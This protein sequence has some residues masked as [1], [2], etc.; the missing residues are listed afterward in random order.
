MLRFLFL[1]ALLLPSASA[2]TD[3]ATPGNDRL[4]DR[5]DPTTRQAMLDLYHLPI[6]AYWANDEDSLPR[7]NFRNESRTFVIGNML[8][9]PGAGLIGFNGVQL[10]EP[11][12]TGF[13][14][15][16]LQKTDI[17]AMDQCHDFATPD[18]PPDQYAYTAFYPPSDMH[19]FSCKLRDTGAS[20]PT[21]RTSKACTCSTNCFRGPFCTELVDWFTT[22]QLGQPDVTTVCAH[23]SPEEQPCGHFFG[24]RCPSGRTCVRQTEGITIEGFKHPPADVCCATG[25]TGNFCDTLIGCSLGGCGLSATGTTLGGGGTCIKSVNGSYVPPQLSRCINCNAGWKGAWCNETAPIFVSNG[26]NPLPTGRR[27]LALN[28]S[29]PVGTCN[30]QRYDQTSTGIAA[31]LVPSEGGRACDCGVQWRQGSMPGRQLLAVGNIPQGPASALLSRI[32]TPFTYKGAEFADKWAYVRNVGHLDEAKWLCYGDALCSGFYLTLNNNTAF[33]SSAPSRLGVDVPRGEDIWAVGSQFA[34]PETQTWIVNR[35][36]APKYYTNAYAPCTNMTLDWS[37]YAS[38][39]GPQVQS[40]ITN[41]GYGTWYIDPVWPDAFDLAAQVHWRVYGHRVRYSPNSGCKLTTDWREDRKTCL[42]PLS[43]VP[44]IT[45][46]ES[47]YT[48]V[49]GQLSMRSY[50]NCTTA[51]G[52]WALVSGGVLLGA[53][54][55]SGSVSAN[56]TFVDA[57]VV[58][59]YV[60]NASLVVGTGQFMGGPCYGRISGTNFT[61]ASTDTTVCKS[62]STCIYDGVQIEVKGVLTSDMCGNLTSIAARVTAGSLPLNTANELDVPAWSFRALVGEAKGQICSCFP[63]FTYANEHNSTMDCGR[64]QC[65]S[66]GGVGVVNTSYVGR[67]T[68]RFPL[69]YACICSFPYYTDPSTCVNGRCNWCAASRCINLG[70]V[71]RS[72][73]NSYA[74]DCPKTVTGVDCSQLACVANHTNTQDLIATISA[75]QSDKM[76]VGVLYKTFAFVTCQPYCLKGWTGELCE[77]PDCGLLGI[78][79]YDGVSN[80]SCPVGSI[81]N[82]DA[83]GSCDKLACGVEAARGIWVGDA[84]TGSCNCTFPWSGLECKDHVCSSST[85]NGNYSTGVP[86]RRVVTGQLS[87]WECSCTW[88]W[89][90]Q[91]PS[92][93]CTENYCGNWGAPSTSYAPGISD[94]TAACKCTAYGRM[95]IYT[96]PDTCTNSNVNACPKSCNWGSCGI[97]PTLASAYP[98]AEVGDAIGQPRCICPATYRSNPNNDLDQCYAYQ[99]CLLTGG[100][101]TILTWVDGSYRCACAEGFS[102]KPNSANCEIYTPIPPFIVYPPPV[103]VTP[104]NPN[105]LQPVINATVVDSVQETTTS[106]VSEPLTISGIAMGCIGG[107]VVLF[108]A[109][110]FY[111]QPPTGYQPMTKPAMTSGKGKRNGRR[112]ATLSILCI[113]L[114]GVSAQWTR[115]S[116]SMYGTQQY[117]F[118]YSGY[119]MVADGY[120]IDPG[121][122]YRS[123]NFCWYPIYPFT[124][125]A[126]LDTGQ[127]WYDKRAIAVDTRNLRTAHLTIGE[128]ELQGFAVS[129]RAAFNVARN[130]KS[131]I[132]YNGATRLVVPLTGFLNNYPILNFAV[133]MPTQPIGSENLSERDLPYSLDAYRS[134]PYEKI[135][136]DGSFVVGSQQYTHSIWTPTQT[137]LSTW[138]NIQQSVLY[139]ATTTG[140]YEGSASGASNTYIGHRVIDLCGPWLK[141]GLNAFG[142]QATSGTQGGTCKLYSRAYLMQSANERWP[143][144]LV[145]NFPTYT[146]NPGRARESSNDRWGGPTNWKN[147]LNLPIYDLLYDTPS[148]YAVAGCHCDHGYGGQ[149]CNQTCNA[150]HAPYTNACGARGT[151]M[152]DGSWYTTF[153]GVACSMASGFCAC[154]SQYTGDLCE[155]AVPQTVSPFGVTDSTECCMPGDPSCS[156][157]GNHILPQRYDRYLEDVEPF[158]RRDDPVFSLPI[159]AEHY[160]R[161]FACGEGLLNGLSRL[162]F[163]SFA[164]AI[165]QPT[166]TGLNT[167]Y[168]EADGSPYQIARRFG[169]CFPNTSTKKTFC[170]CNMPSTTVLESDTTQQLIDLHRKTRGFFGKGCATKTCTS[171]TY[172][173]PL[174]IKVFY[175]DAFNSDRDGSDSRPVRMCS[176]NSNRLASEACDDFFRPVVTIG[177]TTY[178]YFAGTTPQAMRHHRVNTEGMCHECRPGWGLLPIDWRKLA[179]TIYERD[180][181]NFGPSGQPN[182]NGICHLRTFHGPDGQPCGGNGVVTYGK[183]YSFPMV[184]STLPDTEIR[185]VT[186]CRCPRGTVLLRSGICQRTCTVSDYEGR[187]NPYAGCSGN[188]QCRSIA[189]GYNS[190]CMCNL[191][192]NG[193]RCDVKDARLYGKS[194]T[195]CGTNGPPAYNPRSYNNLVLLSNTTSANETLLSKDETYFQEVVANLG[196][197]RGPTV[198]CGKWERYRN[199]AVFGQD[200]YAWFVSKRKAMVSVAIWVLLPDGSAVPGFVSDWATFHSSNVCVRVADTKVGVVDWV[201]TASDIY[202][203]SSV[204]FEWARS[205]WTVPFRRSLLPVRMMD[206]SLGTIDNVGSWAIRGVDWATRSTDFWVDYLTSQ[207]AVSIFIADSVRKRTTSVLTDY[208]QDLLFSMAT[209]GRWDTIITDYTPPTPNAYSLAIRMITIDPF[210]TTDKDSGSL[211]P[212]EYY[213]PCNGNTDMSWLVTGTN[214]DVGWVDWATYRRTVA[215]SD[216]APNRKNGWYHYCMFGRSEGRQVP[217]W[218]RTALKEAGLIAEGRIIVSENGVDIATLVDTSSYVPKAPFYT[219]DAYNPSAPVVYGLFDPQTQCESS[220][221]SHYTTPCDADTDPTTFGDQTTAWSIFRAD[222]VQQWSPGMPRIG[223]VTVSVFPVDEAT[224]LTPCVAVYAPLFVPSAPADSN[225]L[226]DTLDQPLRPAVRIQG[227]FSADAFYALYPLIK[228]DVAQTGWSHYTHNGASQAGTGENRPAAVKTASGQIAYGT[229]DD[230]AYKTRYSIVGVSAWEHFVTVG[231]ANPSINMIL[232]GGAEGKFDG[233]AYTEYYADLRQ[234]WGAWQK[235]RQSPQLSLPLTNGEV[236]I[237]DDDSSVFA[238][239]DPPPSLYVGKNWRSGTFDEDAFAAL[240]PEAAERVRIAG[241]SHYKSSFCSEYHNRWAAVVTFKGSLTSFIGVFNQTDYAARY[242]LSGVDRSPS[243]CDGDYAWEDYKTTG[244]AN[245]RII[246]VTD[247]NGVDHMGQFDGLAYVNAYSD[248]KATFG[249]WRQWQTMSLSTSDDG[250]YIYSTLD[251]TLTGGGRGQFDASS[252]HHSASVAQVWSWVLNQATP[253]DTLYVNPDARLQTVADEINSPYHYSQFECTCSEQSKTLG[254]TV[255]NTT[256]LSMCVRGCDALSLQGNGGTCSTGQCLPYTQSNDYGCLCDAGFGG[257]AC[258]KQILRRPGTSE[259]CGGSTRGSVIRPTTMPRFIGDPLEVPQSCNCADGFKPNTIST[260]GVPLTDK[261]A[262]SWGVCSVPNCSRLNNC[263]NTNGVCSLSVG[264]QTDYFGALVPALDWYCKCRER[265]FAELNCSRPLVASYVNEKGSLLACTGRGVP[266]ESGFGMCKCNPGYVGYA[267]EINIQ[268]GSCAFEEAGYA[269]PVQDNVTNNVT[270]LTTL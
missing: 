159:L 207:G 37:Y 208:T 228:A 131:N 153:E 218:S 196:K 63:P 223:S 137:G 41:R 262:A 173:W 48:Q 197:V 202:F 115:T 49:N 54:V 42:E 266:E 240:Y 138:S 143:T 105:V 201:A 33:F 50:L 67:N 21:L 226:S 39:Y 236:G 247:G 227:S 76:S 185:E 1:L 180:N 85:F 69:E 25:W 212:M 249:L 188:G 155:Y 19:R 221:T 139:F 17:F 4:P 99:D 176:G 120:Y 35:M 27:L 160:D 213:F 44:N 270:V 193:P 182:W 80:C 103:T 2:Y 113:L 100:N 216:I 119:T 251:L 86:V 77:K 171:V 164:G 195:M 16:L 259:L 245:G 152:G 22:S 79:N 264:Q 248:L 52:G 101:N 169:Q 214:G 250:T 161:P 211:F 124:T 179:G 102:S 81:V 82:D 203:V 246:S 12:G 30:L 142:A 205:T 192:W 58:G 8:Y 11:F 14:G 178:D 13:R 132:Q 92:S 45:T 66:F 118:L 163:H 55:V 269:Q 166:E 88:P 154:K 255:V 144:S 72:A 230:N 43:C 256:T 73:N 234:A 18:L 151:L 51:S 20:C 32:L 150:I 244:Y 224:I 31:G 220:S 231:Y 222:Q 23:T 98:G 187:P 229:F 215:P 114:P 158:V 204:D 106:P 36:T 210:R 117:G 24:R 149:Y 47:T 237:F 238:L 263:T 96:R 122:G 157:M 267:C 189:G 6:D 209:Y 83:Q 233:V 167:D 29:H 38:A 235:W 74:C 7:S 174:G 60:R 107:V 172:E 257:T 97:A 190:A 10:T 91:G 156:L 59:A 165:E 46:V 141:C 68:T 57:T 53:T 84:A 265:A 170:W 134:W 94:A 130:S 183:T 177:S 140:G 217:I 5:T 62:G 61:N 252:A 135:G 9:G 184:N 129:D 133:S 75:V 56:G 121:T 258:E 95:G 198:K 26:T 93:R 148:M 70:T 112:I 65:N 200:S 71:T 199:D 145:L 168:R 110:S 225:L 125:Q 232:V 87:Q 108:W 254:Y 175:S 111:T 239:Q 104:E 242:G 90:S 127:N 89:A 123:N 136:T 241:W 253:Y 181:V 40:I 3:V 78:P 34:Q 194:F 186:A 191:G 146:G 260:D 162:D 219:R 116:F 128:D 109:Y 206:G 28:A 243:N 268:R 147:A 126:Q 261:V 15:Y 64:E